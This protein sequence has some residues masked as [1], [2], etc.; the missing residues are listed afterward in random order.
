LA[1]VRKLAEEH[2][3]NYMQ[4]VTQ[5]KLPFT[6]ASLGDKNQNKMEME[7]RCQEKL[8][9]NQPAQCMSAEFLDSEGHPVLFYFGDRILLGPGQSRVSNFFC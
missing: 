9:A 4:E 1:R 5:I 6:L 8:G 7:K 2:L 3:A